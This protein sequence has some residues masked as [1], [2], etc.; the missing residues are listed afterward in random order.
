M[1]I[2]NRVIYISSL[3]TF[4]ILLYTF[5]LKSYEDSFSNIF[6]CL[7]VSGTDLFL[8]LISRTFSSLYLELHNLN[9]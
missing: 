6:I 4:L 7:L 2:V 8:W 9:R 3:V 5:T 1:T